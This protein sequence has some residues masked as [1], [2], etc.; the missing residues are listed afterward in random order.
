M[1]DIKFEC[2]HCSQSMESDEV[3]H[4]VEVQ[5][6]GCNKSFVVP[7]LPKQPLKP[8]K[9]ISVATPATT[10]VE[11]FDE[12][13]KVFEIMPAA[14]AFLVQII[15]GIILTP[16][17]IGIFML[18]DVWIKTKSTRYRL[19]TQRFIV[20]RGIIA[21]HLDEVELYRI[22]DVSVNQG[23]IQRILGYGSIT[24]LANDETTPVILMVGILSPLE[25]K[26]IIRKYYRAARRRE[27]VRATEFVQP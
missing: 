19:T 5:C 16:L 12:E 21:K 20:R 10:A 7:S 6:P 24:V 14:K 22:K 27:G 26:E 2:P 17:V 13:H 11:G 1:A 23:F 9:L 25:I 4:G 15:F 3:L 8:A 18:I